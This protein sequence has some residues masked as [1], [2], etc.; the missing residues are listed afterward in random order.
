MISGMK[1]SV[2]AAAVAFGLAG[3]G[4]DMLSSNKDSDSG[5]SSDRLDADSGIPRTARMVDE[6]EEEVSFT[7]RSDGRVYLYD[8]TKGQLRHN[9]NLRSGDKYL[10]SG[11]KDKIYV[12]DRVVSSAGMPSSN[13]YRLYFD[14]SNRRA[15]R[16]DRD[17]RDRNDRLDRNDK[18]RV[19]DTATVVATGRGS[20]ELSYRARDEGTVYL[21]DSTDDKLVNTFNLERGQTLSISADDGKAV[22]DGKTISRDL[23]TSGRNEY[24]LLFD[25][26]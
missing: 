23:N 9:A 3:L 1:Q 16:N 8:V 20:R 6:G 21:Y 13:Q 12:N 17:D 14:E 26:R 2:L 5:R 24:K 22:L 4:C 11:D 18:G 10:A 15:D 7:A 19:P 25:R